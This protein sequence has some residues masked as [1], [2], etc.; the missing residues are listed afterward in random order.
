M[1]HA[2]S[3][4]VMMPKAVRVGGMSKSS[5]LRALREH[6]VETNGSADALFEDSRFTTLDQR[7][8]VEIAAL[9]VAVLGFGE[10][11]TYGHLV[12]RAVESGLI[13]CPLETGP[14]LRLQYLSQ[15]DCADGLPLT[16][17]RA[18]RFHHRRDAAARRHG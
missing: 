3:L 7:Q 14:H 15:P 12:A 17:G 5:L 10:G 8:L 11:A 18:V 13:E 2:D 6:G 16:R 1:D 9:S 4:R